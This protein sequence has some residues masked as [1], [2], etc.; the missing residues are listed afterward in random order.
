MSKVGKFFCNK[1]VLMVG[2]FILSFG[3]RDMFGSFVLEV[4]VLVWLRIF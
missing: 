1:S 4:F 2:S 3:F